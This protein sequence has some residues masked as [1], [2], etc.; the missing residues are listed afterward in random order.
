[1][2][3]PNINITMQ[4]LC[5]ICNSD[6]ISIIENT[7]EYSLYKCN[8]CGFVHKSLNKTIALNKKIYENGEWLKAREYNDAAKKY[9][10]RIYNIYGRQLTGK[11]LLEI[12]P[13][14]GWNIKIAK[15]RGYEVKC[16]E[17]SKKNCD[18]IKIK[19]NIQCI[20]NKIENSNLDDMQFDNILLSHIIE[21]IEEPMPF[22]DCVKRLLNPKGTIIIITPNLCSL[23][24]ILYGPKWGSFNV[25]D[26]ASFFCHKHIKL[27][28]GTDMKLIYS[29]SY[30]AE[31]QYLNMLEAAIFYSMR[32]KESHNNSLKA[33]YTNLKIKPSKKL[34]RFTRP[35]VNLFGQ[36]FRLLSLT[37][38][39]TDLIFV[40][41]RQ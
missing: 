34:K 14:D 23:W 32:K 20:N 29:G 24:S 40:A 33:G 37:N 9:A 10:E 1:M 8:N 4:Q 27:L 28:L 18:Y 30:E 6:N 26:H 38:Y 15:D 11:T 5:P 35:L 39:G 16:V 2:P 3:S 21:H 13:G 31:H 17:T 12:G 19:H 22:I 7:E 41:R 36:P 25:L